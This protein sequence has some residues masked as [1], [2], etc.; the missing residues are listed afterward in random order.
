M[1]KRL[2]FQVMITAN[3]VAN[4]ESQ[5]ETKE[6]HVYTVLELRTVDKKRQN[7]DDTCN[8][9]ETIQ[10]LKMRNPWGEE[11]DL[12]KKA[13]WWDD[14]DMRKIERSASQDN[15]EF[16]MS[17]KDWSKEFE[18]C[19]ICLLPKLMTQKNDSAKKNKKRR[20]MKFQLETSIEGT[21]KV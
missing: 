2:Y 8:Y 1:R 17:Y 21:F 18:T 13:D 20:T 19:V 16:W 10:L 14:V 6:W 11:K 7:N 5:T 15:G 4:R 9:V 3:R 12:G